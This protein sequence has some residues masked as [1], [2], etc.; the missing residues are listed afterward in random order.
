[1]IRDVLG[2]QSLIE[3]DDFLRL[4][5]R[6]ALDLFF[7]GILVR[8]VYMR[9]YA[10]RDYAFTYYLFNIITFSLCFL[11]RKVPIELGF[12]LGLFAVFGILRY[13]TE[14]IGIR[15][16]TYLFIV[17]GIGILTAVANRKVSLAELVAVNGVI[18]LITGLLEAAPFH[19][20]E[21]RQEVIYDD[22][23]LLSSGDREALKE[24]LRRRTGLRVKR[25]SFGTID[26]LR[27]S[28][29]L[30]VYYEEERDK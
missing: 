26:L 23:E 6:L 20:R 2:L 16:L 4:V 17:I 3:M 27:D 14:S 29:M 7:A 28:V 10:K 15:D 8:F 13:R 1:M 18:V 24:D 30:T 12:A 22:M 9:H 25:V 5:T 11:L 21:G 19:G